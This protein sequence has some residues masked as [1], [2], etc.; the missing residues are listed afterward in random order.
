MDAAFLEFYGLTPDQ[1]LG[2]VEA[3]ASDEDAVA[4]LKEAGVTHSPEEVRG[5]RTALLETP[6]ADPGQQRYLEQ[7]RNDVAPG[8]PELDT[9]A[10]VIA[11]EEGHPLPT[12]AT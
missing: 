3:G 11:V 5:F 9:F 1:F 2:W 7:M 12:P 10:K 6:P 8:R 4:K